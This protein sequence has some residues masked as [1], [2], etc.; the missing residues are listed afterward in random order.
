[1]KKISVARIA[2]CASLIPVYSAALAA[3]GVRQ[4]EAAMSQNNWREADA[5][6]QQMLAAHPDDAR[7]HYLY[8]QVLNSEGQ[9][10]R[11]LAQIDQAKT[12][13]PRLRFAS[14]PRFAQV[15]ARLR[16]DAERWGTADQPSPNLGPSAFAVASAV[17]PAPQ[18]TG[19]SSPVAPAPASA[20]SQKHG[21]KIGLWVWGGVGIVV[22][23]FLL[24]AKYGGKS[25]DTDRRDQLRRVTHLLNAVR[26]LKLDV[27]LFTASGHETLE[28]EARDFEMQLRERLE[29]M[30]D[31]KATPSQKQ[32]DEL[33]LVV[34]RGSA[35]K[36]VML[37]PEKLDE[38]EHQFAELKA[39]AGEQPDMP[40]ALARRRYMEM[41]ALAGEQSEPDFRKR[42]D[43]IRR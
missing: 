43:N 30:T 26:S 33:G 22:A 14:P 38:L 29:A 15:R 13:D 2:L 8:A 20:A 31:D 11:A 21:S 32:L 17:Q 24:A 36:V 10:D 40:W 28:K 27:R 42:E 35:R 1:M 19:G 18:A 39:R 41:K 16:A 23:L 12:L 6:L 9:Y 4:I 7:T 5:G 37:K 25:T 3:P 34:K